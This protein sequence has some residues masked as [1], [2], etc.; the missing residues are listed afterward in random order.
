M[1]HRLPGRVGDASGTKSTGTSHG[2]INLLHLLN[3]R[4]NDLLKQQLCNAV[5]W[6][7]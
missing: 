4:S 7:N 2:V 6:R 1:N 5:S 3:G